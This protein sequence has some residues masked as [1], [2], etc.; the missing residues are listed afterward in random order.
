VIPQLRSTA[1]SLPGDKWSCIP[2]CSPTA[3][4]NVPPRTARHTLLQPRQEGDG[5]K[6]AGVCRRAGE[7]GGETAHISAVGVT[8]GSRGCSGSRNGVAV[9]RRPGSQHISRD[10]QQRVPINAS[11]A[12]R[13]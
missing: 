5:F 6:D 11:T 1:D 4:R 10:V 3:L 12:S 2:H 8:D 13:R 7:S 9:Q